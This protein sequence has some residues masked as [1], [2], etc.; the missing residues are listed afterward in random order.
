MKNYK[1]LGV[2]ILAASIAAG[3]APARAQMSTTDPI[4]VKQLKAKSVWL[5]A[6]VIRADARTIVVREQGNGMAIHTF[7]YSPQIQDAM[8]RLSDQG[9]YQYGDKVKIYYQQGQTVALRILGKPSK[10]L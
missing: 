4:V 1:V 10:P 3:A 9:G 5:K 6:E 2:A 8:Q 7:T